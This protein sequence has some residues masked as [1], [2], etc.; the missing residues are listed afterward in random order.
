MDKFGFPVQDP[1]NYASIMAEK[2]IIKI[3][4]EDLIKIQCHNDYRVVEIKVRNLIHHKPLVY[5]R[6]KNY[7]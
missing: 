6:L 1:V 4:N 3:S 5:W 7:K 2:E